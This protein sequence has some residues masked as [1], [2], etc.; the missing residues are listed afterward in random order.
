MLLPTR[1][2]P[3]LLKQFLDSVVQTSK[4]LSEIEIVLYVDDDDQSTQE[5]DYKELNIILDDK[6]L[7]SKGIALA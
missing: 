5:L 1:N 2:R 6:S 7:R 4:D 3:E